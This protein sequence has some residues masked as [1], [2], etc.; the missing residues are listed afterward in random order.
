MSKFKKKLEKYHLT[1]ILD[2]SEEYQYLSSHKSFS[3][4]GSLGW[5]P[6]TDVFENNEELVVI[7]ELSFVEP[8]NI[9]IEYDEEFIVVRGCRNEDEFLA[10]SHFYKMEIDF[11]P[12]EKIINLPF[13]V[14][15]N[16]LEK[17]YEKGFF[18]IKIKKM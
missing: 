8:E 3:C 10:K 4:D 9:E 6:R 11:G 15:F 2:N 13:K 14:D 18:I 17:I 1:N 7:L 5:K 16:S 12:F